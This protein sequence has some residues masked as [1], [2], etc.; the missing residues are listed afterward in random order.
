MT[1]NTLGRGLGIE[2]FETLHTSSRSPPYERTGSRDEMPDEGCCC[3]LAPYSVAV[4]RWLVSSILALAF[5]QKS[6]NPR[7]VF[8][9]CSEAGRCEN[10]VL[11]GPASGGKG[12][13]YGGSSKN[14]KDLKDL[15][16][17]AKRVQG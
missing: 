3:V 14:L 2:G 9:P 5:R 17:D 12:S 6:S 7:E 4:A 15:K 10:R 8:P 11:D 1:L 16:G 13:A